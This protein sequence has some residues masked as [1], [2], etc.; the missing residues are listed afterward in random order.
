MELLYYVL[1][2]CSQRIFLLKRLRDQDLNY[3]QLDIVTDD[4]VKV[5]QL[6]KGF[7]KLNK[8]RKRE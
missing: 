7:D 2:L 5:L 6:F 3:R 1:T 8:T 4:L